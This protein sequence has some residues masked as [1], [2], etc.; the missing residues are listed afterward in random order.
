M[1]GMILTN[2]KEKPELFNQTL[3]LIEESLGY[4]A[5]YRFD[6]DFYPLMEKKNWENNFLIF[7]E[8]TSLDN[9]FPVHGAALT[10]TPL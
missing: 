1:N 3:N 9:C 8:K 6:I 5:P 2:L 10:P 4:F 7:D